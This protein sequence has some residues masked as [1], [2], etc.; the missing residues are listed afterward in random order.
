MNKRTIVAAFG[1]EPKT[2]RVLMLPVFYLLNYTV[3][4]LW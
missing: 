1:L 2:I 4:S 3:A